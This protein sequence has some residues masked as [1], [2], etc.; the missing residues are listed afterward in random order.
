M[1]AMKDGG[2]IPVAEL[3]AH[4]GWLRALARGLVN[5]EA[6]AE[7]LVQESLL[8]AV[9]QPPRRPGALGAWLRTVLRRLA[10]RALPWSSTTAT[11]MAQPITIH[12]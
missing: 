12:S 3:C 2:D 8:R 4:T 6:L 7:D 5:D 9:E 10:S 1:D 11:M